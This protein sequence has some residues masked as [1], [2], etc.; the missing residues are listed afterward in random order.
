MR[1]ADLRYFGSQSW[2]FPHSLMIAFTARWVGGDIVPQADEIEEAHW[3]DVDALPGIPPRFSI[4]GHLI[5]DAAARIALGL[6]PDGPA[7]VDG[8]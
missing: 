8:S 7:R 6:E 4:S 2:P 3:F 5:R 1:I